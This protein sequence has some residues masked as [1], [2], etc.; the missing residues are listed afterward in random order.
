MLIAGLHKV[1]KFKVPGVIRSK[2]DTE[3][4]Q[5]LGSTAKI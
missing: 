2:F 5:I 1:A 4:P 3:D